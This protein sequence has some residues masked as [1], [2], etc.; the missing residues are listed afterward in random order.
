MLKTLLL[1]TFSFWVCAGLHAQVIPG[2]PAGL[3]RPATAEEL[4]QRDITT[5]SN[6]AGLPEGKGTAS[7]GEAVYRDQCAS[8]HGPNGTGEPVCAGAEGGMRSVTR[9]CPIKT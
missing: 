8:C 4:K 6:G 1:G 5:L 7:Q 3:G 2:K 9:D